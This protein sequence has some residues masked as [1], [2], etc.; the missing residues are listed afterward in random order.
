MVYGR[1][2]WRPK[3]V[4]M[5]LKQEIVAELGEADLLLPGRIARSLAANDR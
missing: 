5:T 4:P 2:Q 3:A 1:V